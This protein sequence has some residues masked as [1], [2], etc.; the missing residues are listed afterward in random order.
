[1]R[2]NKI[3]ILGS[4]ALTEKVVDAL[5]DH[6]NLVGYVPSKNPTLEGKINLPQVGIDKDCDIKISIQYDKLVKDVKNCFN[7]HTGLLPDYGGTNILSYT[8]KNKEK[9]QG[10][11]FHK[12]GSEIDYGPIISKI[13]Y[14]VFPEDDELKLY[15]RMINIAPNFI[16]SC[17][18]LL[19][20]MSKTDIKQCQKIKPFLYKRGEFE[21]PKNLL[22]YVKEK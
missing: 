9:N 10:L 20:I 8:I 11:T 18:N 2:I 4:T 17:L 19:K 12:M 22:N 5:I 13:T 15:K 21:K 3:L 16:L 6:Y 1:M 14:P 7:L